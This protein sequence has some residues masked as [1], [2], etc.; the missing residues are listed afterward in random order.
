MKRLLILGIGTALLSTSVFATKAR[1]EALGEDQFGSQYIS[2]NRN[3]FL[4]AAEIH[5]HADFLTFEYGDT[6]H[7]FDREAEPKATG[8]YF[9]REG[10]AVYGVYFGQDSNTAASLRAGPFIAAVGLASANPA[11]QA[12]FY[13]DFQTLAADITNQNTLDLFYGR[14]A[15]VKW[16]ARLSHSQSSNS[17]GV[18]NG[19][20]RA[21][22][23][24][25]LLGLGAISGD[26]SYYL[27][28]GLNNEAKIKNIDGSLFDDLA[29]L[30]IP[31]LFANKDYS[32]KGG[33]GIQAGAINSLGNGAVAFIEARSISI[34]QDG[35]GD[36]NIGTG[37]IN[38]DQVQSIQRVNLGWA[39][40]SKLSDKFTAFYRG[41]VFQSQVDNSQYI[42]DYEVTTSFVRATVGFEY[43]AK[44]WLALRGS[45]GNNLWSEEDKD[46]EPQ[47]KNGK[48]T[49]ENTQVRLGAG[50]IFGDFVIDGLIANDSNGDGTLDSTS[51]DDFAA[52]DD[53]GVLRTD[54][55]MSRVSM[56]YNF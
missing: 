37:T 11:A 14:D 13:N 15:A 8:G 40:S 29:G 39:K 4:N 56:T 18:T 43:M 23:S 44:E 26:W 51:D 41:E 28:A 10:N 31:A 12:Q 54:S 48:R 1:L 50:L 6:N 36:I 42:K 55:L 25:T 2:D 45:V 35:L 38:V 9:A 33:L 49:I 27:N 20:D 30:G 17:Q 46:G 34:E 24:A 32:V 22:Q 3:M 47:G 19:Y 52:N 53:N 7:V 21:S 5:N 16:G